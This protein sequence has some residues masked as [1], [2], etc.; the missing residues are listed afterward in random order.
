MYPPEVVFVATQP[1]QPGNEV[2]IQC[3]GN[4][5]V[6]VVK[7]QDPMGDR[8]RWFVDNGGGQLARIY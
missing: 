2:D 8:D 5:V 6:A 7:K 1:W 4:D 3:S